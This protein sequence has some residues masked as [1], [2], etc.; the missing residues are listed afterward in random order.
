[1]KT[2]AKRIGGERTKTQGVEMLKIVL[3]PV[4]ERIRGTGIECP[5]EKVNHEGDGGEGTKSVK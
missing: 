2:E 4:Q 3:K 1:V 5:M